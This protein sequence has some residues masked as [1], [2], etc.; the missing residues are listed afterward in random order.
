MSLLTKAIVII[1][2][3][4]FIVA[5]FSILPDAANHPLPSYVHEGFYTIYHALAGM[6]FILPVG[7]ILALFTLSITFELG[8]WL[9][10][11]IR[12]IINT[13]SRMVG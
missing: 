3:L 7:V 11:F 1:A 12:W 9:W 13:V 8:F 10:R 6:D 5:M 2:F 4:A